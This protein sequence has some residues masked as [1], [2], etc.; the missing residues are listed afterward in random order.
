MEKK[1]VK[2]IQ[3]N[4]FDSQIGAKIPDINFTPV[5]LS[6]NGLNLA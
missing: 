4:V 6:F 2:N 1:I 3:K 5:K